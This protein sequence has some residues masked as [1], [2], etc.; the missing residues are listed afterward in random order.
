MNNI[1]YQEKQDGYLTEPQIA[2]TIRQFFYQHPT[3]KRILLII[4]DLTRSGPIGQIFRLIHN[5]IGEQT[6]ALDVLVALGTHRLMSEEDI[7]RRLA[8]T[9]SERQTQYA[10]VKFFNHEWH[11]PETFTTVG[12]ITI[13][14]IE[15][16]TQ[17]LFR[18][19]VPVAIN[20]L[21]F[22]YDE[23]FIIGPVFPHEVM[24]FSGG[25]KYLFPGIAG[26][27]IINFFHWLGA[28][29]TNPAIN[30]NKWTPPRQVVEKAASYIKVPHQL[31]ALVVN[32]DRLQGLYIG[33]T[34][35]AWEKATDLSQ[36]IHIIYTTRSYHTVLGI[37]STR[38]DELWTAGKVMY[39]LEPVVADGGT[40]IIYAPHITEI[41][42][43]H[44]HQIER[45][46]YHIRDYFLQQ[47]DRFADIPRGV[48]AHSTHVKGIGVMENGR[49]KPR[50]NVVLATGISAEICKKINLGYLDSTTVKIRDYENQ[51][52]Q[53]VLTVHHAG[54]VLYRLDKDRVSHI[55]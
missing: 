12:R 29:I 31:F 21:I 54:E 30:G 48:L 49:E 40:L 15:S 25:H 45:I 38:Y 5:Y 41:S 8:I 18:E 37:A 1:I 19:E 9:P 26:G 34:V 2:E 20:K 28:V 4:P 53:G 16:L 43:T 47:M 10:R 35:A 33:E 55:M 11:R 32:N 36:T 44:G 7:C 24:G 3:P 17:G 51:Q 6:Q 50:I 14:D 42:H 46:G 52:D 39:K 23:F 13:E 27:D 22:D